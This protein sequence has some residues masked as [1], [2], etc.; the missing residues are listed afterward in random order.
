MK[1]REIRRKELIDRIHA[2]FSSVAYPGDTQLLADDC[3]DIDEIKELFGKPWNSHWSLVP[4]DVLQR[5]I[6]S[7]AFFSPKAWL[8][9]LPAFMVCVLRH[10]DFSLLGELVFC[11]TPLEEPQLFRRFE[12]RKR[13]LSREQQQLV[14][15]F[16]EFIKGDL[17]DAG[18]HDETA[19]VIDFWQEQR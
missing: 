6:A 2:A 4:E 1:P 8:F 10:G 12:T 18:W 14:L 19:R 9:Y 15:E 7:V 17:E 5:N 11:L 13:Q 16:L 3:C